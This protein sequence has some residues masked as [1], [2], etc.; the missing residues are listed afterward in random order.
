MILSLVADPIQPLWSCIG[1]NLLGV[2]NIVQLNHQAGRCP[3]LL[4]LLNAH[5]LQST[6]LQ[7]PTRIRRS[8]DH[9]QLLRTD[10]VQQ[11]LRAKQVFD[12]PN[13]CAVTEVW[14]IR[15]KGEVF[16]RRPVIVEH[17]VVSSNS[18]T[19]PFNQLFRGRDPPLCLL[20]D[21]GNSVAIP[22][23]WN[24]AHVPRGYIHKMQLLVQFPI[25]TVEHSYVASQ[26]VRFGNSVITRKR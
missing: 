7:F 2:C 17:D 9:V 3:F 1:K 5:I 21:R 4:Q 16:V 8:V 25:L 6:G 12:Q 14:E 13:G 26:A 11:L 15:D 22:G 10:L 20:D 23:I 24:G 19:Y 18:P